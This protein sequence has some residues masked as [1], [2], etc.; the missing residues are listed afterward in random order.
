MILLLLVW[1]FAVLDHRGE[2]AVFEYRT[3][4]SCKLVRTLYEGQRLTVTSCMEKI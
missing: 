4:S 1:W 2:L 3:E